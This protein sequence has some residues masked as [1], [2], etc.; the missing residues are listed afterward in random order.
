MR[1]LNFVLAKLMAIFK[2][3]NLISNNW[4]RKS[5]KAYRGSLYYLEAG[6]SGSR[7]LLRKLRNLEVQ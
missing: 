7:I 6:Q 5:R 1:K 3:G 4:E 2:M